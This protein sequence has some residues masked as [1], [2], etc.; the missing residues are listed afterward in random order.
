L[1]GVVGRGRNE[2]P[3]R[4]GVCAPHS[5]RSGPGICHGDKGAVPVRHARP[6]Y[7]GTGATSPG[8][9][10]GAGHAAVGPS[11]RDGDE[12]LVPK[13]ERIPRIVGRARPDRPQ[14]TV[15]TGH[16]AIADPAGAYGDKGAVSVGDCVP[17]LLL[18][19]GGSADP[20]AVVDRS[21][22]YSA[23]VDPKK[24]AAHDHA[25]AYVELEKG[26]NAGNGGLVGGDAESGTAGDVAKL[27]AS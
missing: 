25:A 23:R 19:R 3:R 15:G 24:A 9:G 4:A 13:D 1:P 22:A 20:D 10:I 18:A 11:T 27:C 2:R 16:G 21:Y 7:R 14:N 17:R 26:A 8:T 12:N 5:P 6:A